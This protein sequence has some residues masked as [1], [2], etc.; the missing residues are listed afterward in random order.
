[1]LPRILICELSDP[2]PFSSNIFW[3]YYIQSNHLSYWQ[4]WYILFLSDHLRSWS[5]TQ[6]SVFFPPWSRS[7]FPTI[8]NWNLPQWSHFD[9]TLLFIMLKH[10]QPRWQHFSY[11]LNPWFILFVQHTLLW[12]LCNIWINR[13]HLLGVRLWEI[14][15]IKLTFFWMPSR[16]TWGALK[17][18]AS[19]QWNQ[20][21]N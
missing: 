19:L 8:A 12:K 21:S 16:S 1:M 2:S 9:S 7:F 17:G 4:S 6:C 13:L 3:L 15:F 10:L 14:I 11:S 18:K 5:W 20:N